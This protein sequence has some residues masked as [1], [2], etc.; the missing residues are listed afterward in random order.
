M[1]GMAG[2]RTVVA[3]ADAGGIRV[4]AEQLGRSPSAVSMM[5]RQMEAELGATLFAGGHRARPTATGARI[6]AEARGAIAHFDRAVAAMRD[7]A[8]QG[9]G[10]CDIACVPSVAVAFMPAAIL[11]L[12]QGSSGANAQV[13]DMDSRAAAEAVASGTV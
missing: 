3:V 13:R 6:I 7:F 4:A 10:R 8:G 2:L 11:A 1:I 9:T 12:R 5:L